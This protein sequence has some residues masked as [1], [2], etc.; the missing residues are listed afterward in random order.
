MEENNGNNENIRSDHGSQNRK[1]LLTKLLFVYFFVF[2]NIL[3]N[4]YAFILFETN[5]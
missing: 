1:H 3:D 5:Q 2:A 4:K